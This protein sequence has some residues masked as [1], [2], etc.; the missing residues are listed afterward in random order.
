[1][2]LQ[3]VLDLSDCNILTKGNPHRKLSK[4]FC[5]DLLSIAMSKAPTDCVWITVMG[6]KNTLA[7]ASL[8][9]TACIILAEGATLDE[10]ILAQAEQEDIAIL[11][12][13]LPIFDIA[14]LIH[15]A[16]L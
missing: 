14:L 15:K 7:V 8:T 2:T 1:M 9:D 11:T 3:T 10:G 13:A 12:T 4:I 16:G 6:N 5:C